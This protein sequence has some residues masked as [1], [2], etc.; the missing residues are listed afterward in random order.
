LEAFEKIEERKMAPCSKWGNGGYVIYL[1]DVN[2]PVKDGFQ[3]VK[4]IKEKI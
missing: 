1:I 2:M 4:A 3:T